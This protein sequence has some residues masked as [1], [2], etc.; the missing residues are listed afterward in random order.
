MTAEI[1]DRR[2][3]GLGLEVPCIDTFTEPKGKLSIIS[4]DCWIVI[5]LITIIIVN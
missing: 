2:R 3:P 1:T 5:R 4:K